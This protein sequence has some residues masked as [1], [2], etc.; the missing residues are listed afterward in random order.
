MISVLILTPQIPWPS[1]Q[2]ASLRNF[3]II[4]GLAA[5]SDVSLL[6]FAEPDQSLEVEPL[7][8]LLRRFETV[9][10]P[11][12]STTKRIFQ[13]LTSR[14]PDMGHRLYSAEFFNKLAQLLVDLKPDVVQIEGIELA[15]T[16]SVI[17]QTSPNTKIVFDNH[18]AETALQERIYETD[19]QHFK[20]LPK[21]LYSRIQVAK[22][23]RFEQWACQEADIVTAVSLRDAEILDAL[24]QPEQSKVAAVP[25]CIDLS[26]Y[27]VADGHG[28]KLFDLVFTGKMDYRPNVDAMLWFTTEIWP[29]IRQERPKTKLAIVGKNPAPAILELDQV[30]GITVTGAVAEIAPWLNCSRVMIM[31]LRMGSGTRLK[32]IEALAAGLP[33]VSTSNGAEGYP[34]E[35]GKELLL[36]NSPADFAK[37]TLKLLDSPE[38]QQRLGANGRRFAEDYDWRKVIPQFIK[39]YR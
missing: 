7:T 4:Q 21:A 19:I 15:R 29:L 23:R 36:S 26:N 25:N 11:Q 20:K 1:H 28:E 27:Q 2:G 32:L 6:S 30:K 35:E 8:S 16:I 17:K 38:L 3:N 33:V 12:R 14:I 10:I 9:P 31:P 5:E 34:L 13:L 24:R 37:Q 39:L 18:N 22:L